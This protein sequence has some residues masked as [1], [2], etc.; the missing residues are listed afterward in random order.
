MGLMQHPSKISGWQQ[1][2]IHAQATHGRQ[3]N[4]HVK[5]TSTA[6]FKVRDDVF[7]EDNRTTSLNRA[8][9]KCFGGKVKVIHPNKGKF[10]PNLII[11]E[12]IYVCT[13][14]ISK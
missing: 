8:L 2:Q 9:E 11:L 4:G 3:G 5:Q 12:S 13:L 14:I 1:N 6:S 10:R 7:S